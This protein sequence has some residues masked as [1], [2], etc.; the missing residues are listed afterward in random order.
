MQLERAIIF[1]RARAFYGGFGYYKTDA[2]GAVSRLNIIK[3]YV[4]INLCMSLFCSHNRILKCCSLVAAAL[5]I[6][7]LAYADRDQDR[8]SSRDSDEHRADDR[9]QDCHIPIV[10][11]ANA[12][13][14][15][16]PFVGAV[17]LFSWRRF[18]GAQT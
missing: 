5:V 12:G 18:S 14:V 1:T 11:E 17:L 15:L 2:N 9:D 4:V 16:I 10:P 7:A 3:R 13:W 8:G 6:P